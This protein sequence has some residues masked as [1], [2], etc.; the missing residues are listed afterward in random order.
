MS[1]EPLAICALLLVMTSSA[2]GAD[3]FPFTE[4]IVYEYQ[5]IPQ[6]LGRYTVYFSGTK[7]R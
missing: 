4:G 6:H 3:H 1:R 5:R 2:S 7:L